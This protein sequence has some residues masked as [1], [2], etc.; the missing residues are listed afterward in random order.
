LPVVPVSHDEDYFTAVA[1]F[2]YAGIYEKAM[3]GAREHGGHLDSKPVQH[4]LWNEWFDQGTYLYTL[5]NVQIPRARMHLEEAILARIEGR[6]VDVAIHTKKALNV[7]T[8]GN[9]DGPLED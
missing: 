2:A 8:Y 4:E 5:V 7:L 9:V 3:R 1:E 6:M